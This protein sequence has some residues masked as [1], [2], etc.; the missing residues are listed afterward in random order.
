LKVW[1][2][3]AAGMLLS[4]ILAGVTAQ[5]TALSDALLF[6]SGV[7]AVGVVL[8]IVKPRARGKYDLESLRAIHEKSVIESLEVDES[9]DFDSVLCT[10][11]GTV[12]SNELPVCPRCRRSQFN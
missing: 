12:F 3:Y 6:V 8:Q 9:V 11:C 5:W 4:L 1:T 7:C 10:C 2:L